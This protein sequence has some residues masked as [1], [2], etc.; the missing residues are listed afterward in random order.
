MSAESDVL[1]PLYDEI[2]K[3]NFLNVTKYSIFKKKDL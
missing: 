3:N 2:C 1:K